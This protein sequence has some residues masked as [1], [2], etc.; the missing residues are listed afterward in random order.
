MAERREE[1]REEHKED[2]Q[3]NRA[4]SSK[5]ENICCLGEEQRRTRE[6]MG[7]LLETVQEMAVAMERMQKSP[8]D[9]TPRSVQSRREFSRC[10][11]YSLRHHQ[12]DSL[13]H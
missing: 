10:R 3:M 13:R 9:E 11:D 7:V 5:D 12:S 4:I 6:E 2:P 8:M 1:D